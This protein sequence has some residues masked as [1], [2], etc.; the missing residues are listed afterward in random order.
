[1][2]IE[3][4]G[5]EPAKQSHKQEAVAESNDSRR[6]R[7]AQLLHSY[8]YEPV[9]F[10]VLSDE[11]PKYTSSLAIDHTDIVTH[12]R[13]CALILASAPRVFFAAVEGSLNT[14]IQERVHNQPSIYIHLLADEEGRAPSPV[15]Y[16]LIRDMIQDYISGCPSEHANQIDNIMPTPVPLDVSTQ[17]HRKYL[18]TPSTKHPPKRIIALTRLIAGIADRCAQIP[19]D[20]H[21]M[22]LRYPPS[23]V[24]YALNAHKR[25]AQH[26]AHQSSN[27]VMN[28]VEDIY[29]YLFRTNV[30]AQH[31]RL[32]QC[33]IYLIFRPSQAAI[34]EI[35][36]SGLL[37]CWVHLG[38]FNAYPA[39]R[40]IASSLRVQMGEWDKHMNTAK[41]TG[42][43]E[44]NMQIL[45]ERAEIWRKALE[46]GEENEDGK[47][48]DEDPKTA[49]ET[50]DVT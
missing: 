39:G 12:M 14:V 38:G 45:R 3:F 4:S 24:G 35:F 47:M 16:L 33:V 9:I 34:A 31:Y 40:S 50:M 23:E 27:Y 20:L 46:W 2:T 19:L 42:L 43:L 15:Q 1:M 32:H 22:P 11:L 29:T 30:L 8:H 44:G 41:E 26:R 7:W 17:V 37:Q 28:L 18:S 25:L 5:R 21:S 13:E 36:C 6:H 49:V 48:A 10:D